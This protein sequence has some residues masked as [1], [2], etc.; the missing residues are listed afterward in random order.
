MLQRIVRSEV[1]QAAAEVQ[2][3]ERLDTA[4]KAAGHDLS[5]I[6]QRFQQSAVTGRLAAQLDHANAQAALPDASA[7]AAA[8]AVRL[9]GDLR[10]LLEGAS[11]LM[12]PQEIQE[13]RAKENAD[14]TT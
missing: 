14:E 11:P 10:S 8:E 5:L 7:A 13:L 3:W 2:R 9:A 6:L 1:T 4:L 12:T